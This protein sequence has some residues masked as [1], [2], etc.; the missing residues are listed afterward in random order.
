[1]IAFW[2]PFCLSMPYCLIVMLRCFF[3]VMDWTKW[4]VFPELTLQSEGKNWESWCVYF[5]LSYLCFPSSFFFFKKHFPYFFTRLADIPES[6]KNGMLV[7]RLSA[8]ID[9]LH[10]G[11]LPPSLVW[12]VLLLCTGSLYLT[13]NYF[14][15]YIEWKN[16]I[17]ENMVLIGGFMFLYSIFVF[18]FKYSIADCKYKLMSELPYKTL[19]LTLIGDFLQSDREH[20]ANE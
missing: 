7:S 12:P 16:T 8:I 4:E 9:N 10:R 13:L 18:F 5:F 14:Q 20:G 6:W 19:L 3:H 15:A 2:L 1:M 17:S 11:L